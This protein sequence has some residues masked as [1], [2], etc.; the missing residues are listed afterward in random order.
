MAARVCWSAA[1]VSPADDFGGAPLLRREFALE[2]GHGA[3]G[4]AVLHISALGL[5]E[6]YL[7]GAPV[8]GDV[9]SPGWSSYEWR[10]R[11]RS[12]DV[13]ALLRER[14]VLGLALGNGWYRG[15]LGWRGARAVYGDRLGAIAQLEVAY[16][17]GSVRFVRH[18]IAEADLRSL[19]EKADGRAVV[20]E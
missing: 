1:M 4:S 14:S 9:L 8:A 13:A 16:A 19:I 2:G 17:D 6:A 15:R 18:T 10:V 20:I 11:Y 5:V 7:N 12:H 3:V